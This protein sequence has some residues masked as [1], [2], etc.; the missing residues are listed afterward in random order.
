VDKIDEKKARGN[1]KKLTPLNKRTKR[2]QCEI[3]KKGGKASAEARA[4]KKNLKDMANMLLALPVVGDNKERMKALGV[5]DDECSN[6]MLMVVGLFKKAIS[7]DPSAVKL[8]LEIIGEAPA[9]E[10]NINGSVKVNTELTE[11]MECLNS[12]TEDSSSE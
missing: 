7:G 8:Y 10:V 6:F 2:E 11:I 3:A 4:K 9:K 5:P 1:P 12:D